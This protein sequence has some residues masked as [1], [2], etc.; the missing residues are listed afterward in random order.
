MNELLITINR[1]STEPLYVQIY[2]GIKKEIMEG[3]IQANTSLPSI[4][5][6]SEQLQ[7]NKATLETAY[8]QLI[9]EGLIESKPR[10]GHYVKEIDIGFFNKHES[11]GVDHDEKKTETTYKYAF[12]LD[13]V[14]IENFPI[15]TWR[16]LTNEVLSY[17]TNH[18]F[19]TG[20][21]QGELGLRR[22]IASY[23]RNSRGVRCS[24]EQIIIGSHSQILLWMVSNLIGLRGKTVAVGEPGYSHATNI[25]ES[26]GCNIAPT[27]IEDD[28]IN[29]G[30]LENSGANL[31][32]TSPSFQ[33]PFGS[34]MK[35]Q[36]RIH[37]LNW[38]VKNNAY[39]I[40]DD[41]LSEYRHSS[42]LIPSLQNLDQNE[43]VIYMGTFHGT[44]LPAINIGYIVLPK[45]L[46]AK[47]LHSFEL[48]QTT[49]RVEQKTLELFMRDGHWEQHRF[50]MKEIYK[51]KYKVTL[52]A[53]KK[54]FKEKAIV[55]KGQTGLHI[56][57]QVITNESEE[58]LLQMAR[59]ASIHLY[60]IS[61]Y[62]YR[63]ENNPFKHP[64]F[65]IGFGGMS[66]D[67]I[68]KG[69]SAL[70]NTWFN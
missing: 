65:L 33:F 35:I 59:D 43:R 37:L 28:G 8:D 21:S 51:K 64:V 47:Y 67:N 66:I 36:K 20:D 38:A 19:N 57:M 2:K 12:N 48:Q 55:L 61:D 42:E 32:F 62:W 4:R 44:L 63:K 9:I 30:D 11:N 60:S 58:V 54:C 50:R 56:V 53:I 13:H 46:L 40:E 69:I 6:M 45:H 23:V 16:R 14:D 49:S 3:H 70:Y 7:V 25:F 26:F 17:G 29:A 15:A 31:V 1:N 5:K 24:E 68:E 41:Y 22:E 34:I 18:I 10:S 39:I 52:K 27:A